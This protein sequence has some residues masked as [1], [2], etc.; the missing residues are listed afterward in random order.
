MKKKRLQLNRPYF[1]PPARRAFTLIELLVVIAIIAILA[2]MLLPVL[3]KAKDRAKTISCLSNLK[4]WGLAQ[5]IYATDNN[6]GLPRDGMDPTSGSYPP[7][8]EDSHAW[9]SL[10]PGYVGEKPLSNYTAKATSTP[11]FNANLLPFPGNGIGKMWQCPSATMSAAYLSTLSGGGISG[12]FSYAMNIDLKRQKTGY[13]NA[14]NFPY[15]QM[16]RLSSLQRLTDTVLMFDVA[17]SDSDGA[18]AAN[19]TYSTLPALR[20]R[21]F[22]RRHSQAGGIINFVDGHAAYWKQSVI[23]NCGTASPAT[24]QEYSGAPVIW[25]PVYRQLNP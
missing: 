19:N 18:D 1:L 12:F 9:F 24:A 13:G 4:Q 14:D 2:A 6:D 3:G 5:Q 10:L 17:F 23:T 8:P 11:A 15:P 16:P 21:S 7:G 20:W 22:P 25:N